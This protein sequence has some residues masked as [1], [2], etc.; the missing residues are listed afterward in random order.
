MHAFNFYRVS[1]LQKA[2]IVELVK[3]SVKTITL[4][5]GDGANDVGMIQVSVTPEDQAQGFLTDLSALWIHIQC[6][7][8]NVDV[9]IWACGYYMYMVYCYAYDFRQHMWG[10][11][12]VEWRAC[13][14]H[15][16][17]ITPSPR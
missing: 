5:I 3:D 17:R 16:P 15:V 8:Y 11:G 14:Q 7:I 9:Q 10:W 6:N 4:A 13:K 2:E 1:P 12:S